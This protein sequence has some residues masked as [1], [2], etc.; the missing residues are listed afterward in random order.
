MK[1]YPVYVAVLAVAALVGPILGYVVG[2]YVE[3]TQHENETVVSHYCDLLLLESSVIG[4]L[5]P[6][7]GVP[8]FAETAQRLCELKASFLENNKPVASAR[9][10]EKIAKS[11]AAWTQARDRLNVL[12]APPPSR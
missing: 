8:E 1:A 12:Q 4:S 11:L 9:N 3:G 6:N 5:D 2:F 7:A 10:Q